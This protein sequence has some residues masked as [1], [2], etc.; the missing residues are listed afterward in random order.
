MSVALPLPLLHTIDP[1]RVTMIQH[2]LLVDWIATVDAYRQIELKLTT[3]TR[4]RIDVHAVYCLSKIYGQAS[5]A[6]QRG[7]GKGLLSHS[8]I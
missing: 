6:N 5:T 2:S 1:R 7:V 4:C 8:C 3:A